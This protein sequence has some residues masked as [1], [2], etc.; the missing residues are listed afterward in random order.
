MAY[1]K[2][3]K[4]DGVAAILG[5][6]EE[7]GNEKST[8][9]KNRKGIRYKHTHANTHMQTHTHTDRHRYTHTHTHTHTH[10]FSSG[11]GKVCPDTAR[12]WEQP[13]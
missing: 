6:A 10:N 13:V 8:R 3:R 5:V 9:I 1:S 12:G 4:K 2:G 7:D 11:G